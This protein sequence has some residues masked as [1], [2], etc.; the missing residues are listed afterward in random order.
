MPSCW[1]FGIWRAKRTAVYLPTYCNDKCYTTSL[2][3]R[4]AT[5]DHGTKTP[6]LQNSSTSSQHQPTHAAYDALIHLTSHFQHVPRGCV[7]SVSGCFVLLLLPCVA[8][9]DRLWRRVDTFRPPPPFM[10]YPCWRCP[11][12]LASIA[13]V[14]G[15]NKACCSA[16]LSVLRTPAAEPPHLASASPWRYVAAEERCNLARVFSGKT[17]RTGEG[18]G[19]G[20][21]GVLD[22]VG[23]GEVDTRRSGLLLRQPTHTTDRWRERD[24][25]DAWRV[26]DGESGWEGVRVFPVS[27]YPRGCFF[28]E[29]PGESVSAGTR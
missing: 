4:E 12:R 24:G 29:H 13:C 1:V 20:E 2:C 23:K 25:A 3:F 19:E 6:Q 26:G 5:W 10:K 15:H 16:C 11:P 8:W 9:S 27:S 28:L 14:Y 18:E 21:G 17:G 7:S 22:P